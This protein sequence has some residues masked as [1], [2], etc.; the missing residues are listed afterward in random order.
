MP[1][2]R[3]R[4]RTLM[5]AV[6]V[7]ATALTAIAMRERSADLRRRA[8]YHA[9]AERSYMALH[10]RARVAVEGILIHP[11]PLPPPQISFAVGDPD[12]IPFARA[13]MDRYEK[14]FVY[15]SAMR[16]KYG[17]AAR[18]PW[19]PVPPDPPPPE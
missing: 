15:H 13:C 17:H 1:L 18:R 8:A 9:E 5:I 7:I 19:L 6:A 16:R 10:T 14:A 3:F 2:P 11:D 4:I 12:E